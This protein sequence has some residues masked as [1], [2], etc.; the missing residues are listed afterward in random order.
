M[1]QRA[2]RLFRMWDAP[3]GNALDARG[4]CTKRRQ[5]DPERL[6]D[7]LRA[8]SCA[9]CSAHKRENAGPTMQERRRDESVTE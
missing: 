4:L 9:V 5:F 7:N 2:L 6:A 8:C 1:V 3:K